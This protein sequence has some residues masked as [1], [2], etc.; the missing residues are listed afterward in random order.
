MTISIIVAYA[1][2]GRA[3]GKDNGLLWNLPE[4]MKFFR[5]MTEGKVV[6]MG[7]TT[8]ESIPEK[9]RPLPNR[10]TFVLTR[11]P[12][13]VIDHPN[14]TVFN[15]HEKCL[16][17]AKLSTPEVMIAG[18]EQIYRLLLPYTDRIYATIV[19]GRYDDADAYFPK[20]SQ[21]EWGKTWDEDIANEQL[22]LF[23]SR[24]TFEKRKGAPKDA[25]I[26]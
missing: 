12:D 26:D 8:Y 10:K 25:F 6:I 24:V 18:G 14:V 23:Y 17:V 3:I 16:M 7:R 13:Y 2:H 21:K 11:D 20:L 4:D 19:C 9:F 22:E 1:L 15:D 5:K